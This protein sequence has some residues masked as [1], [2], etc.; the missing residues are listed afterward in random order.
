[1]LTELEK[2]KQSCQSNWEAYITR[3]VDKNTFLQRW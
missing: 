3:N 2:M 1:M